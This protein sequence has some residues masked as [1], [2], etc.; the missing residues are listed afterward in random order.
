[1]KD[2][3]NLYTDLLKDSVDIVRVFAIESTKALLSKLNQEQN[4]KLVRNF[5]TMIEK[6][7][8]WRV[9]YAA[10]EQICELCSLYSQEYNDANFLPLIVKF[11]KDPEPEVR[12]AVL[13]KFNNIIGRIS[14]TKFVEQIIPVF[15]ENISNDNNHHVRAVFA[16][17]IV[18]CS[19][20]LGKINQII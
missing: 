7:K 10:G 9:K 16:T 17:T 19:K 20:S 6:D 14:M 13:S 1:M 12:T 11:L 3:C 15:N 8:S 18:S 5:S 4:T 2:L